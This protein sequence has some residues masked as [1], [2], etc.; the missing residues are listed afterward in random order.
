[1]E[2]KGFK[3]KYYRGEPVNPYIGISENATTWWEGEKAFY[4]ASS[5]PDGDEF[6]SRVTRWFDKADSE[7]ELLGRLTERSTPKNERVL[8]FFLDLWH[9]KH[10]PYE[11]LDEINK[12]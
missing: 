2:Y 5:A 1:M 8:V 11:S 3:F 12:Y 9:G 10:F 6:I 4:D 7:G